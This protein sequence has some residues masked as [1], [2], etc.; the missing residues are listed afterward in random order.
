MIKNY[1]KTWEEQGKFPAGTVFHDE[2]KEEGFR[3]IVLQGPLH[4]CAYVGVPVEHPLAG[5]NYEDV[6]VSCH[7]GLTYGQ[8]GD[9]K[10]LPK[11][12][13]WYGWDYAHSGDATYNP[14]IHLGEH[15]WMVAEVVKDAWDAMWYF[16][17]LIKL[18][19]QMAEKCLGWKLKL[20]E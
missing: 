2:F 6:P 17:K 1:P 10:Y 7:G 11:G 19:V 12:F 20:E 14:A 5:F 8:A 18:S 4:L 13:F 16:E 3:F 15:K 9:D